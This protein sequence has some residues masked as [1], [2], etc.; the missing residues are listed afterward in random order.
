MSTLLIG[1]QSELNEAE[2][3]PTPFVGA[4]RLTTAL[5]T[6]GIIVGGAYAQLQMA[7]FGGFVPV[8]PAIFKVGLVVILLAVFLLRGTAFFYS[9]VLRD[10]FLLLML[11]CVTTLSLL[12][13]SEYSLADLLQTS[14]L[15]YFMPLIACLFTATPLRI[16]PRTYTTLFILM[17]LISLGFGLDQF[18]TGTKVLPVESA[19]GNFS[20]QAWYM[21]GAVRAFGLFATPM[22]FGYFCCF[23]GAYGV[24][25]VLHEERRLLG[26]LCVISAAAGCFFS[27]TRAAEICF[28]L[29]LLVAWAIA[30]KPAGAAFV[31]LLPWVSILAAV[32]LF[33]WGVNRLDQGNSYDSTS[34]ET[35]GIRVAEWG[36]YLQEY[37]RSSMLKQVIGAGLIQLLGATGRV[38]NLSN[39]TMLFMDNTLLA[40]LM[41]TGILGVGILISLYRSA[42]NYVLARHSKEASSMLLASITMLA[43][44][45]F[46]G[47]YDVMLTEM[48]AFL[49]IATT[50]AS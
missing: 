43:V 10:A 8:T 7:L 5:C 26:L 18:I 27:Q 32:L 15:Y 37:A 50:I 49:L 2:L 11:T 13:S 1:E 46:I 45:P 21:Y 9:P 28:A 35:F 22:Q 29:T 3:D 33:A 20:V 38:R 31:R 14:F 4:L 25:L 34:S 17:F 40:V 12:F 44:L 42:W 23:V 19:D 6:A 41:N 47:S 30:T 39:Q 16:S 48:G 24:M 36:Y